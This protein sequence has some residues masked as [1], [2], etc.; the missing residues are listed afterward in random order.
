MSRTFISSW[1]SALVGMCLA[2][3]CFAVLE[4]TASK[5]QSTKRPQSNRAQR[6]SGKVVQASYDV[7]PRRLGAIQPGTVIEDGAPEGWTHLIIKSRSRLGAGEVDAVP[8]MAADLSSLLFSA[9]VAKVKVDQAKGAT[10]RYRLSG[11]AFGLGTEIK[12]VDTVVSSETTDELDAGF[13][14]IEGMVLSKAEARL[15]NVV[16]VARSNTMAIVDAPAILLRDEKH[17]PVLFRYVVLIDSR[18]GKLNTLLWVVDLDEEGKYQGATGPIEWL[19]TN[20][21]ED[22]ILHVDGNEVTLGVPSENAFA[23]VSPPKGK[24]QLE[25]PEDLETLAGQG[26]MHARAAAELETRLRELLDEARGDAQPADRGRRSKP[27]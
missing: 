23:V 2:G 21:I 7:T 5:A 15:E 12:G 1:R 19:P 13:G 27:R 6:D 24:Q 14:F 9:I 18:T 26:E 20:M 11:L 8:Q 16:L 22:G 3:A 10:K 4:P 25:L 17:T